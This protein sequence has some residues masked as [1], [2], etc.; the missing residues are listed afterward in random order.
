M[1]D[2]KLLVKY[3][4]E[5]SEKAAEIMFNTKEYRNFTEWQKNNKLA[6]VQEQIYSGQQKT[7]STP[8]IRTGIQN[9]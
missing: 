6:K 3:M 2:F 4:A 7:D 1:K 5:K 8:I 9:G